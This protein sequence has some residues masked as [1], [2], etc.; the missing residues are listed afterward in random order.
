M[1]AYDSLQEG[2][3]SVVRAEVRKMSAQARIT[4]QL[5]G[6]DVKLQDQQYAQLGREMA[7]EDSLEAVLAAPARRAGG[8]VAGEPGPRARARAN[9]CGQPAGGAADRRAA[10]RAAADLTDRGPATRVGDDPTGQ[11]TA[12]G[13]TG[14]PAG[15]MPRPGF[16]EELSRAHYARLARCIVLSGNTNDLFPV[17]PLDSPRYVSLEAVL[18]DAFGR[19]R[20]PRRGADVPFVVLTL[21]ASGIVFASDGDRVGHRRHRRPRRLIATRASPATWPPSCARWP[22][23]GRPRSSL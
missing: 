10:A 14:Q 6:T 8:R 21:K 5:A 1:N 2:P 7:G 18:A 17:G 16:I 12:S 9:A 15:A 23:S 20:Y 22:R 19:A 4:E 11:P 13:P 3:S